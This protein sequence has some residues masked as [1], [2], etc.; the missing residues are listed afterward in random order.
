MQ[1]QVRVNEAGVLRNQ[2]HAFSNRYT[3]VTE[4]LQNARRAGATRVDIHH[5]T[6]GRRL[7]VE[8]NGSGL[9]DFQ[10]LLSFH[11]SGWDD[12]TCYEERPFGV[13]FSK[14]LYASTRCVVTSGRQRVDFDTAAALDKAPITVDEVD[15]GACVEGTRIELHGVDLPDL[16]QRIEDLCAGFPVLLSFNSRPVPR[17]L[18]RDQLAFMDSPVGAIHLIGSRDGHQAHHTW[19]FLQG[20]C[21]LRPAWSGPTGVNVVHLDS[22]QFMA[23][24]PDRDRLIDEDQQRL[25]IDDA[26]KACWRQTLETA[27]AELPPRMFVQ[28]Y[29]EVMRS[30]GLLALINDLDHLPAQLFHLVTGY[31]VQTDRDEY[32]FLTAVPNGPPRS[33]IESGEVK[34]VM[35]DDVDADN[36]GRWL[37]AKAHGWLVFDW[38]GVHAEHWVLQHVKFLE[39]PDLR[40]RPIGHVLTTTLEGRWVR[41]TV[42]LCEAVQVQVGNDEALICDAGIARH[43]TLLI[44]NGEHSG[45]PVQQM[46]DYIGEHRDFQSDDRDADRDALAELLHLYRAVDPVETLVT[47]LAPLRLGRYPLLQGKSFALTVGVGAIPG[48]S[49]ELN[50]S[51]S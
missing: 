37:L 50:P 49:V 22:R 42:V 16:A 47:L 29:Y 3:L 11:E 25:R 6:E 27:K 8:D 45:E 30:W 19:V 10:K 28:T 24:L 35:L 7:T 23:R 15:D 38:L 18:A 36:G 5:D 33:A 20:F 39:E 48:H 44:P 32:N 21:V 13:G 41:P 4:L 34:L 14:C 12:A 40:V 17:P 9:D 46:C 2:R 51:R 43:G 1:I 26:L 31:P